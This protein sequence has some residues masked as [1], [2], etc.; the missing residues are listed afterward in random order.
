MPD[1]KVRL[2][3]LQA[4]AHGGWL[5]SCPLL[6]GSGGQMARTDSSATE[7][8]SW[9]DS[10]PLTGPFPTFKEVIHELG[11]YPGGPGAG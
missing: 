5:Q 3:G 1:C 7:L 2:L 4:G 6:W 10:L 9:A 8:S 11:L